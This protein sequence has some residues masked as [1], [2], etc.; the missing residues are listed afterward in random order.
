MTYFWAFVHLLK[1]ILLCQNINTTVGLQGGC[2]RVFIYVFVQFCSVCNDTK[3][4]NGLIG[5]AGVRDGWCFFALLIIKL[6]K[7]YLQP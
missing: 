4:T 3:A 1:T 5:E 6:V 2:T 7:L